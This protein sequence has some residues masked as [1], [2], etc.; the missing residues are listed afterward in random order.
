M[1]FDEIQLLR[2][3]YWEQQLP[4]DSPPGRTRYLLVEAGQGRA[5]VS[6]A[7]KYQED[8]DE[9]IRI[10]FEDRVSCPAR[11]VG[12]PLGHG[13]VVHESDLPCLP[14][15]WTEV[16]AA[17]ANLSGTHTQAWV[18][19]ILYLCFVKPAALSRDG[20]WMRKYVPHF[21][22]FHESRVLRKRVADVRKVLD[23]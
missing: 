8:G 1:S 11:S 6:V 13:S 12:S 17:F 4:N 15:D 3:L 7:D 10:L 14:E 9:V 19:R 21:L 23:E 5:K 20:G 2:C 18:E 22:E 16:A